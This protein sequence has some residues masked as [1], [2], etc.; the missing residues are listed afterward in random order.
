MFLFLII[1]FFEGSH[2]WNSVFICLPILDVVA[3]ANAIVK[4]AAAVAVTVVVSTVVVTD[5]TT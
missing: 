3:D 2:L 1:I 4:S 5:N